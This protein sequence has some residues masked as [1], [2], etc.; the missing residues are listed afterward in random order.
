MRKM[1]CS[2]LACFA[3]QVILLLCLLMWI[4]WPYSPVLWP[5]FYNCFTLAFA[6]DSCL[7]TSHKKLVSRSNEKKS[8]QRRGEEHLLFSQEKNAVTF[9]HCLTSPLSEEV[10]EMPIMKYGNL[11]KKVWH[12]LIDSN[13][14][15]MYIYLIIFQAW[16]PCED[17]FSRLLY[18][19][20]PELPYVS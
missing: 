13:R 3:H 8:I 5:S 17:Q 12:L 16:D 9:P 6:S 1:R 2:N 4:Y 20:T 14:L 15:I 11:Y 10:Y 18:G 19:A 7:I